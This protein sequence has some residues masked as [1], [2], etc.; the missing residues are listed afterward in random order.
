MEWKRNGQQLLLV[1]PDRFGTADKIERLMR[2]M[3]VG[4]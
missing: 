3:V 2:E 1:E 4:W